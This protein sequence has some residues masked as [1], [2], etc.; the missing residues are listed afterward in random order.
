L[1]RW[2]TTLVLHRQHGPS[3]SGS[4]FSS[5]DLNRGSSRPVV[6]RPTK[7]RWRNDRWRQAEARDD[8]AQKKKKKK[9]WSQ[10]RPVSILSHVQYVSLS[11]V[12]LRGSCR[13]MSRSRERLW[14]QRSVL[15]SVQ[16]L[17][18]RE[19]IRHYNYTRLT[20]HLRMVEQLKVLTIK[21]SFPV[22]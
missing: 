5:Q 12:L 15:L 14:C 21:Q 16:T 19:S 1:N 18:R 22:L 2:I 10:S 11:F 8:D 4:A 17:I 20:D 9:K 3:R 6:R 13:S 7:W